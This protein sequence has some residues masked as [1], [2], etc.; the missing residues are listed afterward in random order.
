[1]DILAQTFCLIG[2]FGTCTF[3]HRGHFDM[4]TLRHRDISAQGYFGI[5]D[6]S[7]HGHYGTVDVSA[8]GHFDTVDI[9]AHG[10]FCTVDVLAHGHIS[11]VDISAWVFSAH[12]SLGI[13]CRRRFGIW[14]FRHGGHF[15]TGI[16]RHWTFRHGLFQHISVWE[17][18]VVD[19][20]ARGQFGKF[21]CPV[22]KLICPVRLSPTRGL[23]S[24]PKAIGS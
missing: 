9:S 21:G 13:F 6:I 3:R 12:F 1:M 5:V 10:R 17:F 16:F 19:V 20:S 15:G 24:C 2:R 23:N 8:H 22:R 14:T 4:W 11:T 18:L 7:A